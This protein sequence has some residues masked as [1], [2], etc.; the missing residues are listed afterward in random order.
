MNWQDFFMFYF[1]K[2]IKH[3]ISFQIYTKMPMQAYEPVN[4][5]T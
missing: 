2:W 5:F 3:N 1:Y 4:N